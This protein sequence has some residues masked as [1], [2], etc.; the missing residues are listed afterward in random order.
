[1]FCYFSPARP[2]TMGELTWCVEEVYLYEV[3]PHPG[4]QNP[5]HTGLKGKTHAKFSR[6]SIIVVDWSGAMR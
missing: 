5:R 3:K 6:R 2:Q 1:M 4:K